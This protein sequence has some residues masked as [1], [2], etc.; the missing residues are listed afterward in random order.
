MGVILMR[1]PTIYEIKEIVKDRTYFFEPK[2]MR[3]FGQT[4]SMFKVKQSPTGR[5][6]L[7]SP[8]YWGNKVI[9]FSFRE[10]A[11]ENLHN[12][13]ALSGSSLTERIILDY[14]EEH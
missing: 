13:P 3:S 4:L 2:T 5:I 10:F 11:N 9:G 8:T 1:T 7:Y 12:M 14:I 6:F